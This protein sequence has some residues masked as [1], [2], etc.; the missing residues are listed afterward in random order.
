MAIGVFQFIFIINDYVGGMGSFWTIL[1]K[2]NEHIK[3]LEEAAKAAAGAQEGWGWGVNQFYDI[4]MAPV[5]GIAALCFLVTF[6]ILMM[7]H[8]FL[9]YAYAVIFCFLFTWGGIAIVTKPSQVLSMEGGFIN[10]LKG[11]FIWPIVESV[12]YVLAGIMVD[13]AGTGLIKLVTP[14]ATSVEGVSFATA[15]FIFTFINIFLTAVMIA[16]AFVAFYLSQNQSAM[17]GLVSPFI[18]GGM[19]AGAMIKN[20]SMSSTRLTAAKTGAAGK[21]IGGTIGT[22]IGSTIG[23]IVKD[24]KNSKK[25]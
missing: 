2:Y 13:H 8:L 3:A 19:A 4:L 10:T 9:R 25:R 5:E 24:Y 12:F 17:A 16:A 23:N 21:K 20:I 14:T 1:D 11:L 15:F 7:V 6:A 18:Y 22:K